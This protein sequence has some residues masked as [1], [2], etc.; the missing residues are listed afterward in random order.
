MTTPGNG[1]ACT[2]L[3]GTTTT[4]GHMWEAAIDTGQI[5]TSSVVDDPTWGMK[6]LCRE[7]VKAFFHAYISLTKDEPCGTYTVNAVAVAIGGN[8]VSLSNTFDV[9][10]GINLQTD[11][12]TFNWGTVFPGIQ[13]DLAGDLI[14]GTSNRPT[15]VNGNNGPMAVRIKF[16][17]MTNGTD[18][19]KV[20]DKFDAA[21]GR[22]SSDL[23]SIGYQSPF[24][25]ANTDY[26]LGI[27]GPTGQTGPTTAVQ[28]RW[29]L[30][31]NEKGK[32]DVSI[33]PAGNLPNGNYSGTATIT[34]YLATH[35]L[36]IC[37]GNYHV[38]EP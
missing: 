7:K 37:F 9:L 4:S 10:C 26:E 20:I 13:G 27:A 28:G 29:V 18:V 38:T 8:S 32:L 21:F 6:E 14:F 11:F 2:A 36:P 31:A 15:I 22:N 30:C 12:T 24:L 5:A 3:G 23:N 1:Q 16:G 19:T 17:P 35:L 25:N 33:H 34:G